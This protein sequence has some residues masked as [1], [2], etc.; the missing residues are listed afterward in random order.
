[1]W[2]TPNSEGRKLTLKRETTMAN[3]II[4]STKALS[5][6]MRYKVKNFK[7][8]DN[9]HKFLNTSDNANK[10]RE[11]R[12]DEPTKTGTYAFCGGAYHKITR[13]DPSVLAHV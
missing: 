6:N 12:G 8:R 7:Y 9:M 5:R 4:H 13:L 10:W 3:S 1:M 2:Y 11:T